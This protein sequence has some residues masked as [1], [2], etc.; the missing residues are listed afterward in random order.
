LASDGTYNGGVTTPLTPQTINMNA[1]VY[2][3]ANP[4]LNT[5]SIAMVARVGDA[6]PSAGLSV[7]NTSPDQYTEGL[8]ASIGTASVGFTASGVIVN[9]SA[10]GT[11]ASTLR[12]GLNTGTAG[13]F[14]GSAAL[15]LASTGA[16]TTGA[17]DL[18]L[19][20]Q[21]VNLSGKVYTPAVVKLNTTT[22]NFGIVHKG[23]SVSPV[24]LSVKNDAAVTALNDVLGSF[25][26]APTAPFTASGNLGAGLAAGATDNTSLTVGLNTS[27]AG[28]FNGSANLNFLSR[29]ADMADLPLGVMNIPIEAQINNFASVMLERLSGIGTLKQENPYAFLF[30]FGQLSIGSGLFEAQLGV[31]ND[32]SAPADTLGGDF[33]L[34]APDF[35]LSGFLAF[36]GIEA[37]NLLSG[38][39]I[40]FNANALGDYSGL[41][42]IRPFGYNS[43]GFNEALPE[44]ALNLQAE[45]VSGEPIPEPSTWILLVSGLGT[46]GWIRRMRKMSR[47]K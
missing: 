15:T 20:G 21:N 33:T 6:S 47:G 25:S 44:I 2:R 29:N 40:G 34:N 3:L 1:E 4:T 31:R 23:D 42:T 11:D 8:K 32:A 5:P 45:V 30:D 37:G 17:P 13:S 41:I 36:N 19:P 39:N 35:I 14:A 28:V 9:L 10:G 26:G 27:N 12:V 22:V 43:S 24:A 18:G 16:G 38:L 46:L 7:T